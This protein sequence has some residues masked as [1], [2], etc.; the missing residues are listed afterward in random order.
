M[1]KYM[2]T[3][4]QPSAESVRRVKQ[5]VDSALFSAIYHPMFDT[6]GCEREELSR[7]SLLE[8]LRNYRPSAVCIDVEEY[9]YREL[10]I[11]DY[12]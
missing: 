9:I 7:T 5:R 12:F 6:I 8:G 11:L 10:G 4:T 3:R 1:S 2:R